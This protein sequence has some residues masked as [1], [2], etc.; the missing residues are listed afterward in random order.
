MA[1]ALNANAQNAIQHASAASLAR[2]FQALGRNIE[3]DAWLRRG[4][5]YRADC[6]QRVSQDLAVGGPGINN[7]HLAEY[8]AASVPLHC[9]DGW[10]FLSRALNCYISGNPHQ[11]AHFAYYAELRAA[12]SILAAQ[13]I[14][15]LNQ[16]HLTVTSSGLCQPIIQKIGTHDFAWLALEKWSQSSTAGDLLL[17]VLTVSRSTVKEWFSSGT[18][19]S[20]AGTFASEWLKEWGLDLSVL[21]KDHLLR[22]M[23]S[24]RPNELSPLK[25][26]AKSCSIF[27]TSFWSLFEPSTSSFDTLDKYLFRILLRKEFV[28]RGQNATPSNPVYMS[29]INSML[30]GLGVSERE[31]NVIRKFLTSTSKGPL[32]LQRA[33]KLGRIGDITAHERMIVR[34]GLLLRVASGFTATLIE[35][36]TFTVSDLHF[37]TDPWAERRAF[38]APGASLDSLSDL[39]ADVGTAVEDEAEWLTSQPPGFSSM[40]DWRSQR[41]ESMQPLAE[42]ER[43]GLWSLQR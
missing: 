40:F 18:G 23:G 26:D 14:C 36:A 19:L 27:L 4:N 30:S 33:S 22:N 43:V 6:V 13:G 9:A 12:M 10:A 17:N 24:Y 42:C 8:V 38:W 7:D 35:N 39:W 21:G 3:K 2:K 37:W 41:A 31:R 20:I 29:Y 28:A 16:K 1:L 32:L 25:I 15:V 34:A 11:A 5:R